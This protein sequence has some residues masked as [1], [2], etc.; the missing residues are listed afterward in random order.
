MKY[1]EKRSIWHKHQTYESIQARLS[2]KSLT[3]GY[4]H[5]VIY[6]EGKS[7]IDP[8]TIEFQKEL[9]KQKEKTNK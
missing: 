9:I 7:E 3:S 6:N 4:W 1:N 5:K 8:F 2:L